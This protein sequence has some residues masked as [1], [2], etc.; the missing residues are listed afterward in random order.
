MDVLYLNPIHKACTNHKYDAQNYFEVSPEYGTRHDLRALAD[1]VHQRGMRLVLDGVFNHMGRTAPWFQQAMADPNSPYRDWFFIGS[2]YKLGYRAWADVPNLP[3]LRLENPALRARLFGD[4]DSVVQGYLRDGVDGWRLDVAADIGF[5]ILGD[6]TRAAHEAK[7]GSLVVGEI[8]N[9]PAAWSPAV[10]GVM[11]FHA[12]QII[13]HLVEGRISGAHAGR[14]LERMVADAGLEPILKAWLLLD[15]HDLPRLKTILPKGWQRRMAQILQFTL[16]GSPNVYYG[17]ELGMTGRT[18]PE[19]RGPMRWEL[20]RDENPELKRFRKLVA[21]R[22]AARALKIGDFLL[23][24]SD[25]LLAFM[26]R[27]DRVAE[28]RVIIANPTAQQITDVINLRDSSL[29]NWVP[30]RDELSG[31]EVQQ[32]C[33]TIHVTVPAHKTWVLCPVIPDTHEHNPY[34]RVP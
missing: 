17:A 33:G 1:A 7:P 34:K 19:Q 22:R 20:V 30:L 11:N 23:L 4:P 2:Q 24:D 18:D 16:P 9:Y 29:M 5:D 21:M 8:W 3:E 27:T 13:M 28:T 12:R 6:L 32:E 26:R 31:T 15:N 25:K 10:D 14:M